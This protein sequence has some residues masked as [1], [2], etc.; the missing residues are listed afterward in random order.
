[1]TRSV[2]KNTTVVGAP[3]KA[4][5]NKKNSTKNEF[6]AYAASSNNRGSSLDKKIKQLESKIKELENSSAISEQHK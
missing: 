5:G 6:D 3:A 1:M 2:P 4:V